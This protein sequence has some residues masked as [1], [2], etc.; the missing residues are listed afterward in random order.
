MADDN[1]IGSDGRQPTQCTNQD[2][3]EMRTEILRQ[4]LKCL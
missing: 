2:E 3:Q 4:K 1:S